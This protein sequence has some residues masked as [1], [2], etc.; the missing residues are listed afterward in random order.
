MSL[1]FFSNLFSIAKKQSKSE[2]ID[3]EGY[4]VVLLDKATNPYS[5]LNSIYVSKNDYLNMQLDVAL[6][7]HEMEHIRQKH[8]FDLI[9]VEILQIIFWFNPLLILYKR[10]IRL[11]HEFQVD[12]SIV[13]KSCD[14]IKYQE[15]LLQAATKNRYRQFQMGFDSSFIKSRILMLNAPAKGIYFSVKLIFIVLIMGLFSVSLVVSQN[16]QGNILSHPYFIEMTYPDI[17]GKWTGKGKLYQHDLHQKIGFLNVELEIDENLHISGKIGDASISSGQ[18]AVA[19]Y[20]L[21]IQG[22]LEG[23]I[24]QNKSFRKKYITILLGIP[25]IKT[26]S[27][28][29]NFHL[30]NNLKWDSHMQVG[31]LILNKTD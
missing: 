19:K 27:L 18:I 24:N 17:Y 10:A 6:L 16:F 22:M 1:R 7:Q 13:N 29:V 23:R 25:E 28:D 31:G 8:S 5:F 21:E 15:L 2:V 14:P 3:Y 12:R 11:N 9:L 30:S 4:K 20:G 26:H